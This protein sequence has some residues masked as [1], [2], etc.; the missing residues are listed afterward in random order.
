MRLPSLT[1]SPP[2]IAG[3]T[4][5]SRSTSLPL[6]AL[7]AR[8]QRGEMFVLELFGDRDFGGRLAFVLGDQLAIGP[9]HVA[10]REQPAVGGHELEEF[11]RQAA[12]SGAV[13]HGGRAPATAHRRK[14]PGCAPDGSRSATFG[15]QRVEALEIGLHCVDRVRL[16]REIEQRGRVAAGHA[17]YD[18]FCGCQSCALFSRALRDFFEFF[19]KGSRN[20]SLNGRRKPLGFK[21]DWMSVDAAENAPR[22]RENRALLTYR[23]NAVQQRET[24]RQIRGL[25]G[26][27]IGRGHHA[28]ARHVLADDARKISPYCLSLASPTPCTA[29]IS[30]AVRGLRR[31]MSINVLSAKTT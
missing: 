2:M 4:L 18:G 3:S 5:M 11:R 20:R 1:T 30:A 16:L 22:T 6:T 15:N 9:H 24:A 13:E 8:A 21:R 10:H 7:S 28:A 29:P 31:A 27:S 25:A 23:V 19:R 12:D 26:A 17:G 14:K